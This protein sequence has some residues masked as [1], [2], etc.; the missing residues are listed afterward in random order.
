M[1]I[2]E[3]V[4]AYRR[5]LSDYNTFNITSYDTILLSSWHHIYGYDLVGISSQCACAIV[6]G[7]NETLAMFFLEEVLLCLHA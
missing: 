4:S 2:L 7:D 1:L 6:I 5:S 3:E